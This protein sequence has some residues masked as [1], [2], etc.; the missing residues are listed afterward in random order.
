MIYEGKEYKWGDPG[1]HHARG[2]LAAQK[3]RAKYGS[4]FFRLKGQ[5]GGRANVAKNGP[6]K[7]AEAGRKGFEATMEK[8]GIEHFS[9]AG[10]RSWSTRK[11]GATARQTIKEQP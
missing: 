3:V 11:K 6:E 1:Y 9:K 7:L 4:E 2:K 8:Y 10:K 5:K